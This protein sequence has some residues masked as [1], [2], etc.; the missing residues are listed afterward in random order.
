MTSVR[1]SL[2]ISLAEKYSV[3]IINIVSTV[4][5]ARLLTPL[6]I[7]VYSVGLAFVAIA[8][9]LRDFGVGNYLIQE[10][11]LTED[12]IRTAAGVTLLLA[13]S[14]ALALALG[15]GPIANIYNKPDM[16]SVLLILSLSFVIIPFSSPTLA[17]L[18]R[19][20]AF[21]VLYQIRIVSAV[22][23][24]SVAVCLSWQGYSF[25]SLAWA[26]LAGVST[27]AV[28]A[29]FHRPGK[30]I[31]WPS[32]VEWRHVAAF[33]GK[34]SVDA[35]IT[36]IGMNSIDMIA[37]RML[38][39]TAVGIFSRAQG[40][41]S[42]FSREFT[43][44]V[45]QVA[46]PAFANGHRAGLDLKEPFLRAVG[47]LT[48]FAWPFYAFL[49]LMA[50]PIIRIMFGDQWDAAVPLVQILALGGFASALW[51]LCSQILLGMGKINE[52]LKTQF[53]LQGLRIAMVFVTAHYSITHVAIGQGI[54][55]V[56]TY[57]ILYRCVRPFVQI[58]NIDVMRAT[59]KSM[60][61]TL[62]SAIAPAL[63]IFYMPPGPE[64]LWFPLLLGAAG[65]CVGWLA[66]IYIFKHSFGEE[67]TG[68]Y[69]AAL[70]KFGKPSS[71]P[72]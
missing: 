47:T 28:M 29:A 35:L 20:M 34:A 55:Y 56:L 12:R 64:N 72:D 57:F 31:I 8:H 18:R 66:G 4:I 42:M 51:S 22:V 2:L 52:L 40:L 16:R 21:K 9:T 19:N 17:L 59:W 38:G 32:F 15:S 1:I 11:E 54:F 33:G 25:A 30:L 36:Q 49:V 70:G 10:K 69:R 23:H 67:I 53:I 61:A 60:M 71:A 68:A 39:F 43:N 7:G 13:W 46:F 26:S 24:A 3:T 37:G 27:T 44:A 48:L 45:L 63:V 62:I 14:L 6:E 41:I 65:T 5:I 50:Y 58:S